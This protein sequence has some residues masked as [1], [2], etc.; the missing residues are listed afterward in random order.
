MTLYLFT[1]LVYIGRHSQEDL[2]RCFKLLIT[3]LNNQNIDFKIICYTNFNPNVND[4]NVTYRKYYDNSKQPLYND[5][6]LNLSFNKINIYKDLYD[7][8]GINYTWIDLDTIVTHDISYL[9]ELDNFFII[10]GGICNTIEEIFTNFKPE[11]S[12]NVCDAI[13]GNLWK[14]NID[15]YHKLMSTFHEESQKGLI[16]NYDT[17]GLF[18]YYVNTK[19]NTEGI[20]IIGKNCYENC[21][22]GLGVWS[23]NGFCKHGN[24]EAL[25]QM[26][27]DENNILRTKYYPDKEIHLISF[28]FYTIK[29]LWNNPLF[30]KL[31]LH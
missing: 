26:Y 22:N 7:E 12:T 16:F 27:Y 28:T 29:T 1:F 14:L 9:S 18:N 25:E 2:I 17:Q 11:K 13:Q 24:L 10:Q 30:K 5:R 31:F 6:W 15:L 21:L 23:N 4:T 19:G 20:N 3:S 8:T